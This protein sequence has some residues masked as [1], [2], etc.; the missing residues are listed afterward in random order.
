MLANEGVRRADW[1]K[2]SSL[3]AVVK[4]FFSLLESFDPAL[5]PPLTDLLLETADLNVP[6][7]LRTQTAKL[8]T[9]I[10]RSSAIYRGE[11]SCVYPK[12]GEEGAEKKLPFHK[13]SAMF[14][15]PALLSDFKGMFDKGLSRFAPLFRRPCIDR[16][17]WVSVFL[18]SPLQH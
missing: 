1:K 9:D 5:N 18:R 13:V 14:D 10:N 12:L 8:W 3:F 17:R 11:S 16:L 15:G 7:L 2:E 6:R 4:L